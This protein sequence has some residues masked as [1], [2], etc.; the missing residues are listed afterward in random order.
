MES[1]FK[2]FLILYGTYSRFFRT[3]GLRE[4][5]LEACIDGIEG[6]IKSFRNLGRI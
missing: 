3:I 4:K 2:F 1:R 6:L 5:K